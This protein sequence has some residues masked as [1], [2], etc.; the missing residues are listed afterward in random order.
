MKHLRYL[1]FVLRHRWFVFVASCRLGVPW[2]GLTHDL[3]KFR[4]SEWRAYADYFYGR[5]DQRA[6]DLA[7]LLHQHRNAHHWQY[8]LLRLDDGNEQVVAM[9]ERYRREMVADW[10]GAGRAISGTKDWRPW[11]EANRDRIVVDIETRGWLE[12]QARKGVRE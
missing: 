2:R 4:P 6:F 12:E 3:S 1:R 10:V 5:P 8:W 7:W 9:P 11:Y